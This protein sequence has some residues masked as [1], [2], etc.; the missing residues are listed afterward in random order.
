MTDAEVEQW[1]NATIVDA[2]TILDIGCGIRP[3]R[4]FAV[5]VHICVEPFKAYL[6]RLDDKYIKLNCD[7]ETATGIFPERSVDTIIMLDVIEHIEKDE[8]KRLLALTEKIAR[9]QIII[10]TPYGFMPSPRGDIKEW[11]IDGGHWQEH[12]SGWTEE[13]FEGY[14]I[15][16]IDDR[17]RLNGKSYDAI[18]AIKNT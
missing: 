1:L 8:A 9:K 2:E 11:K 17:F 4:L 3:Q 13:D 15:A 12:K 7:W 18:F 10:F 16:V 6:D 5:P 14:E